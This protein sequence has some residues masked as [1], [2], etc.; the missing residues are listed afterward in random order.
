MAD[1]S[2]KN[3]EIRDMGAERHRG[4][5][6]GRCPGSGSVP[7]RKKGNGNGNPPDSVTGRSFQSVPGFARNGV[8]VRKTSMSNEYGSRHGGAVIP[9]DSE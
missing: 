1:P 8:H 3:C 9:P 6:L 2:V 7:Y 4:L 5:V